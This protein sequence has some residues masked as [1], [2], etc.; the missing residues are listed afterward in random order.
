MPSLILDHL[1]KTYPDGTRAL[2][3]FCLKVE[4][5]ELVTV[6]GPS[7]CG[8][9][10]L[11]RLV[12]GLEAATAGSVRHGDTDLGPLSPQKRDMAL[13]F[14][15]YTLFPNLD[16][17]GNM[18]FGLK[19][20]GVR[21]AELDTRVREAAAWL[22]IESLLAKK[23]AE[24][25]GGQRQRAALGRA[26]LRHPRA[27]LF[28]E[29]LSSL[30]AQMRQ[31]LRVEIQRLQ[32]R[33][34]TAMLYVT[35]DQTEALTL[36][37]RVVVL[38]GGDTLQIATPAELV[39]RPRNTRVAAFIGSPGMNLWKGTLTPGGEGPAFA[40]NDAEAP[41]E[42]RPWPLIGPLRQT[43]PSGSYPVFLGL[44]PEDLHWISPADATPKGHFRLGGTVEAVE[45]SGKSACLHVRVPGGRL[46][47][48]RPGFV[49][50]T[51]D[52]PVEAVA[53]WKDAVF[54]DQ[55]GQAFPY[56]G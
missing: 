56:R 4:E 49:E 30:D 52:A 7:G 50:A 25:S 5:G 41:A 47:L 13:V 29:P 38:E 32:R 48:I 16:L 51:L 28:D 3:D 22:G 43:L 23:P 53:S 14:Q 9:S 10:T 54:F 20:R 36:G 11:L 24:V 12:A 33:A 45:R 1:N 2:R 26:L 18:A 42:A 19:L 40:W 8:K 35:H 44:R 6:V 37:N 15:N 17:Y 31:Q 46:S 21:G 55:H 34:A 27:F 39:E